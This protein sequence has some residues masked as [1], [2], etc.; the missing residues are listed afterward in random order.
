MIDLDQDGRITQEE[1]LKAAKEALADEDSATQRSSVEVC[2]VWE[3]V[4]G[5]KRARG[6]S[7][8]GS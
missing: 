1:F 3:S 8:R 7:R 2:R 4:G 5:C 6:G